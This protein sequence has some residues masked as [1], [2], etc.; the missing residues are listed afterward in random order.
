LNYRQL[1]G[2]D[3]ELGAIVRLLDARED[4]PGVAVLSGEAGIGKSALWLAGIDAA[5]AR[6]YRIL[7]SRPSE[8]ETQFSF[9]GLA[10][11]IGVVVPDVLPQLPRPQRRALEAALALSEPE[12]PPA[13]EGVVAFAF[14]S[15]VRKLAVGKRLLLAIDD[16][17]WLDAPSLALLRYA[18]PRLE[19][20]P[21]AA[22]LTARGDFPAW[23]RRDVAAER[24][25]EL[26]LSP[27]SVGA[28]H[29]LLRGRLG[30][31]LPRPLLLRV[32][33]VSG[34][35]PFFA[36]E[37]ARALQ[38]RSGSPLAGEELPLST[39]LD[40]LVDERLAGLGASAIE[41][42]RVVAALAEPTPALVEAAAGSRAERGLTEALEAGVL[43]LEDD[44]L[45]FSHPLLGSAT[46]LRSTPSERRSLHARLAELVRGS[47]ER[48]RHRALAA[49]G[50]SHEAAAALDEAA[51]AA[52][53][54]GAPEVAAEL[55]EQAVQL[56]PD[57][58][59][60][61]R[62]RR[63]IFAADLLEGGRPPRRDR[64]ARAGPGRCSA[65]P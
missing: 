20:E 53:L 1:V 48:A 25:L 10:D 62:R 9:A 29:E 44:R 65:W 51:H 57:S 2:R 31:A 19:G 32:W 37:L 52:H 61:E 26:D 27:L 12:A 28:L 50:P 15:T 24:L 22:V 45:R 60:E 33:E 38:R 11:L 46:P 40:E 49:A 35:N 39:S 64:S 21:V 18:L 56:T 54:R 42:A 17:Q 41:V 14:L 6:G 5:A 55:A 3:E 30:V 47:E 59:A 16:V 7:S 13:E 8:P 63:I 4:L 36:L 34:G 43:V 23:L 58:D